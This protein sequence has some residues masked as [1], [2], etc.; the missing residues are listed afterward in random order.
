[1]I[2]GAS[3]ESWPVQSPSAEGSSLSGRP[4]LRGSPWLIPWRSTSAP[5]NKPAVNKARLFRE[6]LGIRPLFEKHDDTLHQPMCQQH[7]DKRSY[8]NQPTG[9]R[10]EE[11]GGP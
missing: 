3:G 6:R 1:M 11:S 7:T 4:V 5:P 8:E 9:E 2:R 10:V